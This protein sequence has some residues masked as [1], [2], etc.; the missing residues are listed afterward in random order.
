MPLIAPSARL[1]DALP[2][3]A[4]LSAVTL[5]PWVV[6]SILTVP[7]PSNMSLLIASA[8]SGPIDTAFILCLNAILGVVRASTFNMPLMLP[9][10]KLAEK[11]DSVASPPSTFKAT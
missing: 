6:I 11:G 5:L 4:F 8:M 10:Y 3:K 1:R 9:W 2:V 7:L